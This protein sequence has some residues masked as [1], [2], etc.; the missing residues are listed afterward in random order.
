MLPSHPRC[1]CLQHQE[2]RSVCPFSLK[3]EM[4][5]QSNRSEFV[6]ASP[7]WR[8]GV[9]SPAPWGHPAA[10]EVHCLHMGHCSRTMLYALLQASGFPGK[11]FWLAHIMREP[12]VALDSR[13]T[14]LASQGGPWIAGAGVEI[15]SNMPQPAAV[16]GQAAQAGH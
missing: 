11:L 3:S 7:F 14:H 6:I 12:Q 8:G 4:R 10:R 2:M 1:L 9:A 15:G 5:V 16:N 13:K